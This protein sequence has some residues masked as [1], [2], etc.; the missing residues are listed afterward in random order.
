MNK[1]TEVYINVPNARIKNKMISTQNKN[2][3]SDHF[4][5]VFDTVGLEST[6]K[7]AIR[8]IK[9]CIEL[10]PDY[11][12]AYAN[13]GNIFQQIGKNHDAEIVTKKAIA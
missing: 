9:K 10:K 4:D 12:L 13:L 3:I 7:E 5:I 2:I 8:S 11:A 6:R 1:K